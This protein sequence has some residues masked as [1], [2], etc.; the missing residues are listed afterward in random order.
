MSTR[1]PRL[2]PAAPVDRTRFDALVADIRA[3]DRPALQIPDLDWPADRPLW[4]F[5]YG[6]LMW[7]PEFPYADR[8]YAILHGYHRAFC[9]YSHRYRG[10]PERPGLVL[11][12]DAGGSCKGIAYEVA[13]ADRAA[14]LDYL[15]NR[16]MVTG[17]YRPTLH[18]VDL[19][20]PGDT[21]THPQ[22]HGRVTACCFVADRGH[23]QYAGHLPEAEIRRL[24]R[25]GVGGRGPNIEYLSQTVDQLRA[26]AVHD[27]RL[28]RLLAALA[29]DH[30][31]APGA[32]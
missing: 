9:V 8:R 20:H 17:I 19:A 18:A 6:S 4:V 1:S 32:G 15:W 29:P 28:E 5:G 13:P 26:I 27:E 3:R 22:D 12:L 30:V 10:T 24:I 25:Q 31:S 2:A 11:G 7:N 14:V 21:V 16:E 23:K